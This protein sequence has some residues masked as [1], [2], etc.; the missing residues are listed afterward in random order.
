MTR[1]KDASDNARANGEEGDRALLFEVYSFFT[2]DYR[3]T[4]WLDNFSTDRLFRVV[5]KVTRYLIRA[6]DKIN[7]E[8]RARCICRKA[9][10]LA[11][12]DKWSVDVRREELLA[13]IRPPPAVTDV[14]LDAQRLYD[15]A[16]RLASTDRDIEA[17]ILKTSGLTWAE[18]GEHQGIEGTAKQRADTARKRGANGKRKLLAKWKKSHLNRKD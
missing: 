5:S 8:E 15:L 1:L 10:Y 17:L 3:C 4:L 12:L 2:S 13:E 7:N 11:F 18:V 6:D 16:L 9:A 14:N